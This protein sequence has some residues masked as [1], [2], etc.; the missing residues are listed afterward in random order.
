MNKI[1]LLLPLLLVGTM[2]CD[3]TQYKLEGKWQ[4]EQIEHTDD[5]IEKLD[6]IYFNFMNTLFSYQVYRPA[7]DSYAQYPGFRHMP[8]DDVMEI[9]FAE[10]SEFGTTPEKSAAAVGWSDYKRRF[11]IEKL[12][13]K[14]L[15]L[16][17]EGEVYTFHNF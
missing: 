4:I 8:E 17:S 2:A 1:W 12:G 11:R 6:T 5:R 15:I 7:T 14:Q 13:R 10:S 9:E 16:S 3:K